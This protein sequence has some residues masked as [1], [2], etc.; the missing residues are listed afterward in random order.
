[1]NFINKCIIYKL[2]YYIMRILH[3]ILLAHMC[4]CIYIYIYMYAFHIVTIITGLI[5]TV[6]IILFIKL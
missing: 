3:L 5:M 1:M 6:L 2:Y 4:V